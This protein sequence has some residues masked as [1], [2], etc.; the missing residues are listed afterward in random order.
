[1]EELASMV[2]QNLQNAKEASTLADRA[3]SSSKDGYGQ[4]EKMLESMKEINKSSDRIS[5]VIKIIDDIAFQTNIL[6]LNAAVEAARAGEAGMGFAVVADEVKNLANRSAA[7]AKE[8]SGMIEDSIKKTEEGFAIATRMAEVFKDIL[9]NSQKVSEMSKEVES[10]S[11]QQDT[12]INQ[13]NKAIVQFDE[14]VQA[15]AGAAEETASS[16]VELQAQVEALNQMVN[17]LLVVVNGRAGTNGHDGRSPAA[18]REARKAAAPRRHIATAPKALTKTAVPA[19]ARKREIAPE[20]L[21]PFEEDEE[22]KD[23]DTTKA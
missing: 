9:N 22:F 1:M 10:A 23:T 17:Q 5:K 16:A 8:T 11:T 18:S 2:R 4:M 14:V 12:G 7:A 19:T 13:V 21:I 20:T 3:V 15:N 6:A